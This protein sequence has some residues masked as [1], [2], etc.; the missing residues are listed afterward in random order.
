[1]KIHIDSKPVDKIIYY[2]GYVKMDISQ[3]DE[4]Y[5]EEIYDFE[6]KSYSNTDEDEL[7]WLE[8]EPEVEDIDELESQIF[9]QFYQTI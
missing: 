7:I 4:E 3:T 8:G 1:M 2:R 9:K 5:R 6:I